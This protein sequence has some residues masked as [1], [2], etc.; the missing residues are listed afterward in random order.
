MK[1]VYNVSNFNI[2]TNKSAL[3]EWGPTAPK[4]STFCNEIFWN[5]SMYPAMKL[6]SYESKRTVERMTSIQHFKII[7]FLKDWVYQQRTLIFSWPDKKLQ[8]V[9]GFPSWE[10]FR[11]LRH[12]FSCSRNVTSCIDVTSLPPPRRTLISQNASLQAVNIVFP[13][14]LCI[15]SRNAFSSI[16]FFLFKSLNYWMCSSS[17]HVGKK[18]V[19]AAILSRDDVASRAGEV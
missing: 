4:Q 5:P 13:P 15:L 18:T 6:H 3:Q 17:T 7:H 1:H 8:I 16:S 9:A 2:E 10:F 19:I 12:Y 14:F 11:F